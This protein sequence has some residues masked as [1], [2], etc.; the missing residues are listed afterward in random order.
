[1]KNQELTL[2]INKFCAQNKISLNP[3]LKQF[4]N[5]YQK[6]LHLVNE[7]I[8]LSKKRPFVLGINGC[9]GSGK[10]TLAQL[11]A[12]LL[13]Q[14]NEIQAI[15]VSIDDFYK[16]AQQRQKLAKEIHPLF[17][18][19]GVPG[20]HDIEFALRVF[21]QLREP[22]FSRSVAIPKFDKSLD[23]RAHSSLWQK[24]TSQP[25]IIILEG[26]CVSAT[27]QIPSELATPVNSLERKEDEHGKWRSSVNQALGD[28]Y[29]QLFSLIDYL[30]FLQAPDFEVVASWRLEQEAKLSNKCP[31]QG[32]GKMMNDIEIKDFVQF[33]ERITLDCLHKL[34]NKADLIVQLDNKRNPI[35]LKQNY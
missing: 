24:I 12:T 35:N 27:P 25:H 31:K 17:S 11:L 9:Q 14:F 21:E 34:P 19:R 5:Y 32:S 13:K 7:Q 28:N 29:Q 30:I 16:T 22:E 3:F 8:G 20:T 15:V 6:I 23:D 1:M 4:K 18:T 2:I 33:F 26:W 10:T